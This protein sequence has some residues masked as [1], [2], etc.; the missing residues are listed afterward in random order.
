[1]ICFYCIFKQQ[2]FPGAGG[3]ASI[4]IHACPGMMGLSP[5]LVF[6]YKKSRNTCAFGF[7]LDKKIN[8]ISC[9][10]FDSELKI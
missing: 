7:M 6:I 2:F 4:I 1:M 10:A 5:Q 9:N 3:M 8:Q